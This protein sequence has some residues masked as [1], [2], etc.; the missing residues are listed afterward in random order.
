MVESGNEAG[1]PEEVMHALEYA[2]RLYSDVL[3]WYRSAET[4]HR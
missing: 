1:P 3:G 4:R 2:R